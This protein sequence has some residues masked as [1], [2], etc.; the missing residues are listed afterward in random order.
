MISLVPVFASDW[1][2]DDWEDRVDELSEGELIWYTNEPG[3]DTSRMQLAIRFKED[4]HHH[5]WLE[6]RQCHSKLAKA[7]AVQMVFEDRAVRSL[8]IEQATNIG[9][10]YIED[11]TVQLSDIGNGA[12]ICVSSEQQ[13]LHQLD[14]HHWALVS[15]PFQR[16][17]LDGFYPM[18]VEVDVY[19]QKDNWRF[20]HSRPTSGPDISV[21]TGQLSM[22][23][24]FSG[25][26]KT[27]LVFQHALVGR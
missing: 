10:A 16:R 22:R 23:A 20:M 9:K 13:V 3:P 17:F 6:V 8:K 21:H 15:G 7:P 27:A 26:L 12:R 19:W 1:L 4:S 11:D 18:Y 14:K 5:G 25:R 24:H 2:E